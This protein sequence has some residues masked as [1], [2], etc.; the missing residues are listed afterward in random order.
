MKSRYRPCSSK[1]GTTITTTTHIPGNQLQGHWYARQMLFLMASK[2]LLYD[3]YQL[4]QE[5]Q[6]IIRQHECYKLT[7]YLG[8]P[9]YCD[10]YS[11][12]RSKPSIKGTASLH[13]ELLTSSPQVRR[14]TSI[15]PC[16]D[17]HDPVL[18]SALP[19]P[20]WPRLVFALVQTT[21][22]QW[23]SHVGPNDLTT[24]YEHEVNNDCYDM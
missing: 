23:S 7:T 18:A 15:L 3:K 21:M 14:R 11:I 13:N 9:L 4:F 10:L 22:I 5:S 20:P 12:C 2:A 24:N 6:Y 17:R 16:F 1:C 8:Y 19:W